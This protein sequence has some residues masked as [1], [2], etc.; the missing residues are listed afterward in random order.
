M[1]H[2]RN[3]APVT[4]GRRPAWHLPAFCL[5]VGAHVF[6]AVLAIHTNGTTEPTNVSHECQ[7]FDDCTVDVSGVDILP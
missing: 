5:F 2:A 6:G 7:L 4:R 1:R 3:G